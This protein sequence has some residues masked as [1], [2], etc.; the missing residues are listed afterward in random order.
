LAF[1]VRWDDQLGSF[2]QAR[3]F[4]IMGK[5]IY[6]EL[7]V[8]DEP[9]AKYYQYR[10]RMHPNLKLTKADTK[11]LFEG[12]LM[13]GGEI[14]PN[15]AKALMLLVDRNQFDAAALAYLN[16]KAKELETAEAMIKGGSAKP[17][18]GNQLAEFNAAI[19]MARNVQFTNPVTSASYNP[20]MY[21]VIQDL[22]RQDKIRVFEFPR[23]KLHGSYDQFENTLVLY[24][25]T[26]K[27]EKTD[28]IVHEVTHAIQD[29]RDNNMLKAHAEADAYVAG[30]VAYRQVNGKPR[31]KTGTDPVDVAYHLAAP[32]VIARK[33][34]S[35]RDRAW[36]DAH[37]K[38]VDAV[39]RT[40]TYRFQER[41]G[42]SEKDA[43]LATWKAIRQ[44]TCKP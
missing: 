21:H 6:D 41:K 37:Q 18:K 3:E 1:S 26:A 14:T 20:C 34:N 19:G 4:S 13:D 35:T 10:M 16:D 44:K 28:T 32:L 38:V 30:A 27:D 12:G 2:L 31:P 43:M 17:L 9:F 8:L 42:P 25:H 23:G 36:K 7:V 33:A 39:N 29:W 40:G 5:S 22:V 24:N 15:E 11:E